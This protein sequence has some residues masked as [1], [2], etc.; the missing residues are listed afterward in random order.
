MRD[1]NLLRVFEAVWTT[2]SV[3]RAAERLQLTQPAVSSSLA[4]LR[5]E[6]GDPLFS[7]IGTRMEPTPLCARQAPAL[8]EALS[9]IQRSVAGA[10][11]FDP[12]T[13]T[14]TFVL[15]IRDVGEA[16]F[17]PHLLAYCREK[18]PHL[19]FETDYP[20]H[21]ESMQGLAAGRID[22]VVGYLPDLETGIHRREL[23][24][25]HYICVMR[26]GHPYAR[27]A[28]TLKE[29][30]AS[31]LL[32]VDYMGT[33]HSVLGRR[34]REARLADR[35][36]LRVPQFL[37]APYIVAGSDLVWIV[38]S[39]I[40]RE[41]QQRFELVTKACPLTLPQVSVD[42][43]WHDRFHRDPG[44]QWLRQTFATLFKGRFKFPA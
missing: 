21:E 30:A 42:L 37:G 7:R 34:L 36:K 20:S 24:S 14:R 17:L 11:S 26:P 5:R 38:P 10:E 39:L 13:S 16:A 9:L 28:Y 6:F 33:G 2:R 31:E 4:R 35:V 12:A 40:A 29:M 3:S 25:D 41:L 32:L 43:Y 27:R 18:A 44:N 19:S 15:R 8:L 23:Y 1:L 22:I